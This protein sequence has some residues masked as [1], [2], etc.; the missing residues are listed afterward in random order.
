MSTCEKSAIT[1]TNMFTPF[2]N[3]LNSQFYKTLLRHLYLLF[4]P[5]L[6]CVFTYIRIFP[7]LVA[8]LRDFSYLGHLWAPFYQKT[9]WGSKLTSGITHFELRSRGVSGLVDLWLPYATGIWGSLQDAVVPSIVRCSSRSMPRNAAILRP[10]SPRNAA[11][12]MPPA[13]QQCC[14]RWLSDL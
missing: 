11:T 7:Q 13:S 9:L 12:L 14:A 5:L 2:G 8:A 10:P 6:M 1:Q 3:T 4:I